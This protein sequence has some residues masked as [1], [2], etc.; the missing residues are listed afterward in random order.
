MKRI[1]KAIAVSMALM[2]GS[3]YLSL[4]AISLASEVQNEDTKT[5]F[6]TR[7]DNILHPVDSIYLNPHPTR[8]RNFLFCGKVG[9]AAV[10]TASCLPIIEII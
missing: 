7:I 8:L 10:D 2:T 4:P 3:S 9:K 5:D 6:K 1:F